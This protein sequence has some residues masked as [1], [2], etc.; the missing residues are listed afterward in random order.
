MNIRRRK[1]KRKSIAMFLPMQ[2]MRHIFIGGIRRCP[3]C[4][5]IHV[6]EIPLTG[7]IKYIQYGTVTCNLPVIFH[8]SRSKPDERIEPVKDPGQ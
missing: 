4:G 7:I 2:I 6:V 3:C 1:S 8:S 5:H